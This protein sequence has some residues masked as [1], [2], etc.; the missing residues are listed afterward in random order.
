M[1][2]QVNVTAS[3]EPNIPV[4]ESGCH[5]SIL[6]NCLTQV[7]INVPWLIIGFDH[8]P[9]H[10]HNEHCVCVCVCVCV[11]EGTC[12]AARSLHVL[13]HVGTHLSTHSVKTTQ[14]NFALRSSIVCG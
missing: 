4:S 13:V 3:I 2:I 1:Y 11:C 6:D 7:G 14:L 9:R 8:T 10:P 5:D 12:R